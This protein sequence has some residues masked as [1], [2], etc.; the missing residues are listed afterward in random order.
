MG[1]EEAKA[2]YQLRNGFGE[3]VVVAAIGGGRRS[4]GLEVEVGENLPIWQ[5]SQ[6]QL[7]REFFFVS[8]GSEGGVGVKEST[9]E[10]QIEQEKLPERTNGHSGGVGATKS[11]GV[12]VPD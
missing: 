2:T 8:D 12:C 11:L 9:E 4:S 7:L 1:R 3:K 5:R 10:Y 6:Q